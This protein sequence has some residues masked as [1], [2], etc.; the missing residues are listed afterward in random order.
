[1]K[2]LILL[3]IILLIVLPVGFLLAVL[4]ETPRVPV[5][6]PASSGDAVRARAIYAEFRA[7]AKRPQANRVLELSESDLNSAVKFAARAVPNVRAMADV[8]PEQVAAALSVRLPFSRWLNVAAA[9][10]DSDE[11]LRVTAFQI[12][13]LAI[14]PKAVLPAV[15]TVLDLVLGD[16]LGRVAIDSVGSVRIQD[17]AVALGVRLKRADRKAIMRSAKDTVRAV[18]GLVSAKHVR[19][20]WLALDTPTGT[21]LQRNPRTFP[22][23]LKRT[24]LLAAERASDGPPKKEMQAALIALAVYCG[25]RRFQVVVGDVVPKARKRKATNCGAAT[26]LG[27]RD[28]RQHFAISLGLEAASDANIAFAVGEFKEILDSGKSGTG[29]SFDDIAADRAGIYFATQILAGTETQWRAVAEAIRSE[30]SIMPGIS[31]LPSNMTD[32]EFRARFESVDSPAYNE[33][34]REIDARIARL[35]LF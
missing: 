24:V 9:I 23:Y 17:N 25:H 6:K 22:D 13:S 14:P 31:G 32:A 11:G 30:D 3:L 2:K 27:R 28:L 15:R 10:G 7:L 20:Y 16:E 19:S 12:G 5:Q 4:E 26:L 1:M 8:L 34:L 35:P 21:G 18:S 29:F 33:M